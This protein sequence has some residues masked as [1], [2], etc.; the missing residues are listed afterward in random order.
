MS[1]LIISEV[2]G[3][4]VQGEGALVGKPT[5]FVRSGACSSLSRFEKEAEDERQNA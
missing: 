1:S 4:T 2:F 3:P 5:V